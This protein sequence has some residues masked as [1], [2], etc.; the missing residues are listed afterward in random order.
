[1]THSSVRRW[2]EEHTPIEPSLLGSA[3]LE[4]LVAERLRAFGD[5]EVAYIAELARSPE[6]VDRL[7]AG[8]AVP[9]TW[10]FRYPRSY[11]L[12]L[13]ILERRLAAG[14]SSLRMLSIG[15]ATGQEPYC[16]AMTALH[17]GW[18]ADR[19]SVEGID[20]NDGF[21]RAAR[22]GVYG[23]SS[24]R[25]EIPA[26]AVPFLRR[27]G[28]TIAIDP[29]V[30]AVVRFTRADVTHPGALPDVGPYDA[31]FCRNVLIYLN[32][33]ARERL[34]DSICAAL[35]PDGLLFVGHAEQ[36]MRGAPALR[37]AAAPHAF[38]LERFDRASV[39]A[40]ESPAHRAAAQRPPAPHDRRRTV[41]TAAAAPP[42]DRP[43]AIPPPEDSVEEACHIADSGR[44]REAEVMVRTIIAERGP[45]A[46][47]MELLGMIRMSMNDTDGAKRL[48]EQAVYL[49]PARAASLLQLA[50]ISERSGEARRAAIYWD[51]ARRASG[52][53]HPVGR[54]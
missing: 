10:L 30:R 22:L 52:G 29:T 40:P 25:T 19:V 17:A 24:V 34:L 5:S 9:E 33:A 28:D 16:V 50:L 23:A 45:S 47:A 15:C 11:D 6:E 49:E 32:A 7:I 26:W 20:R 18:P 46:P 12:L 53:H 2:L 38:A 14:A 36:L 1:M 21:L 27:S 48:F 51:R 44:M 13:Q 43:I 54:A 42:A 8:I 3:G 4:P 35:A 39:A 31:V 41:P 37:P